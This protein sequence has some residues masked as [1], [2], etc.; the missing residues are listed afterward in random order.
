MTRLRMTRANAQ[1]LAWSTWIAGYGFAIFY[2][3]LGR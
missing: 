3:G 1:A 2:V